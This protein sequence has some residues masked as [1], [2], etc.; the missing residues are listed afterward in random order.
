MFHYC[1]WRAQSQ[2]LKKEL[3]V[4]INVYDHRQVYHNRAWNTL[5]ENDGLERTAFLIVVDS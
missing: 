1:I 3:K 2:R 5:F 4:P